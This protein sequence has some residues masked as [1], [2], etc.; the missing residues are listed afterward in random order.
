MLSEVNHLILRM[1]VKWRGQM[2]EHIGNDPRLLP[3]HQYSFLSSVHAYLTFPAVIKK[4]LRRKAPEEM[5]AEG[6]RL[7]SEISP[8]LIWSVG[9][10]FLIGREVLL[11]RRA[12]APANDREQIALVLDFWRRLSSTH[13]GDGKSDNSEAGGTNPFLPSA[14]VSTLYRLL[15][16]VDAGIRRALKRFLLALESYSLLLHSDSRVGLSDSGPYL[17]S[18]NRV[19]V[20]RDYVG[21]KG[22]A[23]PWKE[24]TA[25]F[26]YT[27]CTLAFTL[28][29]ADFQSLGVSDWATL[30]TDPPD[31]ADRVREMALVRR[32]DQELTSLPF[33]Q[34]EWILRAAEKTSPKLL[35]WFSCLDPRQRLIEGAKPYAWALRPLAKAAGVETEFDWSFNAEALKLAPLYELGKEKAREWFTRRFLAPGGTS[36]FTP[37][38]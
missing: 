29:P 14:D 27:A 23:Y 31:Y 8:T 30:F 4:I 6:R 25:D 37:L 1:G 21:L 35:A 5:A 16:P 15:V 38:E 11:D 33:T 32:D 34:M 10:Y 20:V 3:L 2:V 26:P 12:I 7:G 9:Y 24:A 13:R 22:E 28:D 18:A 19:M 17:L 36:A